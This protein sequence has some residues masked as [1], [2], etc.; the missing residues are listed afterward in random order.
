MGGIRTAYQPSASTLGF[1][2]YSFLT[3]R[4]DLVK[5]TNFFAIVINAFIIAS[6]TLVNRISRIASIV[7]IRLDFLSLSAAGDMFVPRHALYTSMLLLPSLPI[8]P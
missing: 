6:H 7:E 4:T 5:Q 8:H 3:V 2:L 1:A